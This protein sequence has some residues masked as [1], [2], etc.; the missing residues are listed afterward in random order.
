MF[1]VPEVDKLLQPG[2]S[3][4]LQ[5]SDPPLRLRQNLFQLAGDASA[6]TNESPEMQA[7][8]HT[9]AHE[10]PTGQASFEPQALGARLHPAAQAGPD[11][12]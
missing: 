8:Y 1:F 11:G 4:D 7:V 10:G 9:A 6:C 5:R 2:K 3:G 12:V